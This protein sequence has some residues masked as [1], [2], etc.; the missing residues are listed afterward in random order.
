[1]VSF[2]SSLVGFQL[3]GSIPTWACFHS[4]NFF[5][6]LYCWFQLS[7]NTESMHFI[8]FPKVDQ[9]GLWLDSLINY[10][11]MWNW[12][13]IHELDLCSKGVKINSIIQTLQWPRCSKGVTQVE[14][15]LILLVWYFSLSHWLL[16]LHTTNNM[17]CTDSAALR[18]Q[19]KTS[20]LATLCTYFCWCGK[21][22]TMKV[23]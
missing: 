18:L 22:C 10:H 8:D 14:E 17:Y 19:N 2:P 15:V 6:T 13:M 21:L 20:C 7:L 23:A 4:E 16:Q 3:Y 9:T 12:T 11:T 5:V 1:M